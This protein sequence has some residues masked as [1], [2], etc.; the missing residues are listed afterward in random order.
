MKS[1]I[2]KYLN[3]LFVDVYENNQLIELK[4]EIATNLQ[5]KIDDFINSGDSEEKAFSKSVDSLGDLSELVDN[6][7][8]VSK[9]KIQINLERPKPLDKK[10]V[11]GYLSSATVLLIGL[12]A[13]GVIYFQFED[14]VTALGALFTS[15]VISGI[16]LA[17]YGLTHE[18][19][20]IY[21]MNKRRALA[22]AIASGTVL[23]GIFA[24]IILYMRG[25][26]SIVILPTII[27]FVVPSTVIL[28]F[29]GLTE[30]SRNKPLVMDSEWQSQWLEYYTNPQTKK[31][32]DNVSGAL[33]IF[34]VALFLYGIL[35]GWHHAWILF[36]V[37][38]G[39]QILIEV[40]FQS[41]K[42]FK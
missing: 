11:I 7:K 10:H 29:L 21:G 22:Y 33:W 5:E 18:T 17:Y 13:S 28:V 4:E 9:D 27:L 36:I 8:E 38:V 34:T 3:D 2:D 39:F 6:L 20:Y 14:L 32:K 41:K 1:K 12:M 40:Y 26:G 37:A 42:K 30:S 19:V 16:L 35:S 15:I 25:Q 24:P 31:V 23:F